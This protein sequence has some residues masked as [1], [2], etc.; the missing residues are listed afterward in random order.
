MAPAGPAQPPADP[1]H[2]HLWPVEHAAELKAPVLGLYGG[3]DPLSQAAPAMEEA[4]KKAGKTGSSIHVYPDAGHGFH[5]DY[6]DSYV[7]A[8]AKDGWSRLLAFYAANGAA[9]RPYKAA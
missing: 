1:A 9:P 6:R 4:L 2:P 7:E 5:A 3:K 8:D